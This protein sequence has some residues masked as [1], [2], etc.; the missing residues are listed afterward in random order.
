MADRK[1]L[2]S[3][4]LELKP[5]VTDRNKGIKI[6]ANGSIDMSA[7]HPDMGMASIS[8]PCETTNNEAVE[9]IMNLEYM[10]DALRVSKDDRVT[11]TYVKEGAPII[12]TGDDQ[13]SLLMPMR[14]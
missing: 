4:V 14:V 7:K 11:M 5:F 2:L 8:V 9:L 3:A 6:T 10:A 13:W 1:K 12:F